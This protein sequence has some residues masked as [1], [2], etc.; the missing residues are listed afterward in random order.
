VSGVH[1]I[2]QANG[3][4]DE[5]ELKALEFE[6]AGCYEKAIKQLCNTSSIDEFWAQSLRTRCLTAVGKL[7]ELRAGSS[8]LELA[9]GCK[10][11][12]ALAHFDPCYTQS[13][14]KKLCNSRSQGE[15][16]PVGLA[17]SLF[18]ESTRLAEDLK[19]PSR[20]HL[21]NALCFRALFHEGWNRDETDL[22]LSNLL[23]ELQVSKS[24][25]VDLL[26]NVPLPEDATYHQLPDLM[27]RLRTLNANNAHVE[28]CTATAASAAL[29]GEN[30][31]LARVLL[32]GISAE[33]PLP[34][35]LLIQQDEGFEEGY[36]ALARIAGEHPP[37]ACKL[38]SLLSEHQ[39]VITPE[40]LEMELYLPQ[41]STCYGTS[42]L[43]KTEQLRGQLIRSALAQLGTEASRGRRAC[44]Q[45]AEW[46]WTVSGLNATMTSPEVKVWSADL[47][48]AAAESF[49]RNVAIGVKPQT[50]L[51]HLLGIADMTDD[52]VEPHNSTT[53]LPR[54]V[55]SLCQC[56]RGS[57]DLWE[58]LE[59]QL[60]GLA[61]H[62]NESVR[63]G[64][65]D[66]ITHLITNFCIGPSITI[67]ASD[68]EM[69]LAAHCREQMRREQGSTLSQIDAL[70]NGLSS[71]AVLPEERISAAASS[72]KRALDRGESHDM[73]MR[74][75]TRLRRDEFEAENLSSRMRTVRR[76]LG[77]KIDT[78]EASLDGRGGD[79]ASA[80]ESLCSSANTLLEDKELQLHDLQ[81]YLSALRMNE[82]P[83]PGKKRKEERLHS[84][85]SYVE[86]LNSK[87]RP[88]RI[89]FCCT[90]G[91]V[92]TYLLKGRESL[93]LDEIMAQL[94]YVA[95]QKLL[96]NSLVKDREHLITEPYGVQTLG[97][98]AGLVE[99]VDDAMTLDSIFKRWQRSR[100]DAAAGIASLAE[101]DEVSSGDGELHNKE[102][103]AAQDRPA[104]LFQRKIAV[105]LKKYNIQSSKTSRK[106]W[107]EE[108]LRAVF[109][110]LSNGIPKNMIRNEIEQAARCAGEAHEAGMRLTSK[111]AATS[112]FCH[113][114]GLGDRHL[115]N[116]LLDVNSSS[117]V[118]V[119]MGVTFGAG[120]RLRVP[121]VVPFRLTKTLVG[122][123]GLS[124]V[125]GP[126]ASK[127]EQSLSALR[128]GSSHL[129]LLIR[130]GLFWRPPPD[131]VMK[132]DSLDQN[133]FQ[134][135]IECIVHSSQ[136]TANLSD[137]IYGE[138]N[139]F[140]QAL[141]AEDL[142]QSGLED[143]KEMQR[144]AYHHLENAWASWRRCKAEANSV[145]SAANE[146]QE[147]LLT[148]TSSAIP[149]Q[150][151]LECCGANAASAAIAENQAGLNLYAADEAR[152]TVTRWDALQLGLQDSEAE[153][154]NL[155]TQLPQLR[156]DA[157]QAVQEATDILGLMDTQH[158]RIASSRACDDVL[159]TQRCEQL[160]DSVSCLE[161]TVAQCHQC[162]AVLGLLLA[163]HSNC[164][165][166][167]SAAELANAASMFCS[168][169]YT[170]A[171][172]V[173]ADEKSAG[174]SELSLDTQRLSA[175]QEELEEV[176]RRTKEASNKD[177]ALCWDDAS[178]VADEQRRAGSTRVATLDK[179]LEGAVKASSRLESAGVDG[180]TRALL[181]AYTACLR[182]VASAPIYLYQIAADRA[183]SGALHQAGRVVLEGVPTHSFKEQHKSLS[184]H[185]SKVEYAASRIKALQVLDVR[186]QATRKRLSLLREREAFEGP[187]AWRAA[188]MFGEDRELFE[189]ESWKELLRDINMR[190]GSS[191]ACN[192][193]A[194]TEHE[195]TSGAP[196]IREA[197]WALALR[198]VSDARA[199]Y[200]KACN[201]R[202]EAERKRDIACQKA[203]H[204][205]A[206]LRE[207]LG[208]AHSLAQLLR[209]GSHEQAML[210]K[211]LLHL[212]GQG[213]WS[214][215][216]T[217]GKCID[218]C[219]AAAEDA[220]ERC[221]QTLS[222]EGKG[223]NGSWLT[224]LAKAARNL[225]EK[226]NQ[227]SCSLQSITSRNNRAQS[228]TIVGQ[229]P[230]NL[231]N[232]NPMSEG[233][234]S[235]Y[236]MQDGERIGHRVHSGISSDDAVQARAL[237]AQSPSTRAVEA[238][239]EIEERLSGT[240]CNRSESCAQQAQRLIEAAVSNTNLSRM[241][242]GWV[243]WV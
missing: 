65:N 24:D 58:G 98:H 23:S 219:R 234:S 105:E 227:L 60:F 71:M 240:E 76:R 84:V 143:A 83:L 134:R 231:P 211:L 136:N 32:R 207:L 150:R 225:C 176:E 158:A 126:F 156:A 222:S 200:E 223:S 160:A 133:D 226:V 91:T 42:D 168:C 46:L 100:L 127:L 61:S 233:M 199:A 180:V 183:I 81:P 64:A 33:M 129:L 74:A 59:P 22:H 177:L 6:A 217:V 148:S 111:L 152:Q 51:L 106:E 47:V 35:C 214:H 110:Q 236:N 189:R 63:R 210:R 146:A 66:V 116:V 242:E 87:T 16:H 197:T 5:S 147:H 56:H 128:G 95:R 121:E 185:V 164:L 17:A 92:R 125:N 4:I 172:A 140:L 25:Y 209:R 102:Y 224:V 165:A 179:S 228:T 186:R 36:K 38:A 154:S 104:E 119:D 77:R 132:D 54:K 15:L 62:R 115:G 41:R 113:A 120:E 243:A 145:V 187:R 34:A 55:M 178:K 123:L 213:A 27:R 190:S 195:C 215:A 173:A 78:A 155:S 206:I 118:H 162:G 1:S 184:F 103:E 218:A 7:G 3:G 124:G 40:D 30:T 52:N 166:A 18:Q 57:I 31:D 201:E 26:T 137:Y 37:A 48:S 229:N 169:L 80:I 28:E 212:R 49:S 175:L 43:S 142:S 203:N 135:A 50:S 241:Y 117:I 130:C 238:C 109:D 159:Y 13:S 53:S 239:N 221:K 9:L 194:Q 8:S 161:S 163:S 20:L 21:Q 182:D 138:D 90:D 11:L 149:L 191:N 202:A 230:A 99:W 181:R 108:A 75:L 73:L 72:I 171:A 235:E 167:Q 141:A 89:G 45:Y 96:Q 12:D 153:L 198:S 67:V 44:W 204:T 220:T 131:W 29:D 70:Y 93:A 69:S 139:D 68:C 188:M 88:K 208:E 19:S 122:A 151:W 114:F 193:V 39:G 196:A 97:P 14:D 107:P 79:P 216:N 205:R 101:D 86:V 170:C 237:V 174:A 85:R 192:T 112:S 157:E 2:L 10:R 94:T 144:V 82:I 232:S